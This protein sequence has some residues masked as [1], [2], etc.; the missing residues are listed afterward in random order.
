MMMETKCV[1]FK[2]TIEGQEVEAFLTEKNWEL[3]L[4]A[5]NKNN[6]KTGY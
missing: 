3:V 5:L 6:K 1:P 2:I 4:E